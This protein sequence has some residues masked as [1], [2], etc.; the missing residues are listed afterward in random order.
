M[1]LSWHMVEKG[2]ESLTRT[3]HEHFIK[4][5]KTLDGKGFVGKHTSL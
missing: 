1:A 5:G 3:L 4:K 2:R